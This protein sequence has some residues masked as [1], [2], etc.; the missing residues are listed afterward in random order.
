L[1]TFRENIKIMF[2]FSLSR[3]FTH[4]ILNPSTCTDTLSLL[5][6]DH[7]DDRESSAKSNSNLVSNT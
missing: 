5:S 1:N 2:C 7:E 4:K 3:V 6:T